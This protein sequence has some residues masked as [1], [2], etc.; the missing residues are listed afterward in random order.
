M[1]V[2][3][4]AGN[5]QITVSISGELLLVSEIFLAIFFWERESEPPSCDNES[6][7]DEE[8]EKNPLSPRRFATRCQRAMSARLPFREEKFQEKPL[9][10]A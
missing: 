8:R 4:I 10:P 3:S 5:E 2:E 9:G 1:V 7:R 6:R